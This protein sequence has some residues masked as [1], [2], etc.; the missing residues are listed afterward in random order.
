[1]VQICSSVPSAITKIISGIG[2]GNMETIMNL[3][4]VWK[5]IAHRDLP[6][7]F[8]SREWASSRNQAVIAGRI[9]SRINDFPFGRIE[10]GIDI[11]IEAV[12]GIFR[13][14]KF[15]D[16]TQF[17]RTMLA[18]FDQ[19]W[20]SAD[21]TY[22]LLQLIKQADNELSSS[23]LQEG[24]KTLF[25]SM[26]DSRSLKGGW[27][28]LDFMKKIGFDQIQDLEV[29]VTSGRRGVDIISKSIHPEAKFFELKSGEAFS[30]GEITYKQ[31]IRHMTQPPV[32][33]VHHGWRRFRV[34]INTPD[35]ELIERNGGRF[36]K[37]LWE[38]KSSTLSVDEPPQIM[39]NLLEN[40]KEHLRQYDPDL[41]FREFMD[42][43]KN[44]LNLETI[45][46]VDN[47]ELIIKARKFIGDRL[48]HKEHI[49]NPVVITELGTV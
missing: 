7:P 38:K 14:L 39:N 42:E 45:P 35:D 22:K 20:I 48:F 47:I 2:G 6:N 27:Y 29:R 31:M 5:K 8:Y 23:H 28:Q 34:V 15:T 1:M 26:I 3:V 21:N 33:D 16:Q 41:N 49:P 32:S 12:E 4:S 17:K 18:I 13:L 25:V 37:I 11:G 24:L 30:V 10:N 36:L 40:L 9:L 44:Y 19:N 46:D 43:N